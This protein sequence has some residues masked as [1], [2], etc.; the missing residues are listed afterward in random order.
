LALWAQGGRR[1]FLFAEHGAQVWDA[2]EGKHLLDLK[3]ASMPQAVLS[4]DGTR[5][6]GYYPSFDP[7]HL[8][9]VLW[10]AAT[11]RRTGTLKGHEK[12]IT[13]AAFGPDGRVVATASADGTARLW[14]A[15]TGR[16]LLVL[17]G[18]TGPVR[19]LAFSLDGHRSVTASDDRTARIWD[20]LTGAEWLTLAGHAGAVYAAEF[21]PDGS[22][23]V[24]A[25]RDGTARV[26]P[27]DPLEAARRRRPRALT[28][29]ERQ[30]FAVPE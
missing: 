8:E 22:R 11:G 7:G 29:E 1:V 28:S 19:G 12:E 16:P 23:V 5:L 21:S 2:L 3:G 20:A 30:R 18:H 25:S 13:A 10:D 14:E 27:V 9:A 6:V 24:T 17:R 15:E 26:W 4:P